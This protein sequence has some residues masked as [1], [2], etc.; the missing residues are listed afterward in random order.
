MPIAHAEGNYFADPETLRA[1]EGE[2]RVAFRY[3]DAAGTVSPATN[4][5]GALNNI[6]GIVSPNGRVL[7]LMPHP[8]RLFEPALGGIDG[9]RMFESALKSLAVAA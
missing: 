8:E 5:N 3:S 2:G 9:R 4:P 6:A 1:L 7:G